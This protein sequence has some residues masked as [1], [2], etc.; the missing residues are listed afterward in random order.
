MAINTYYSIFENLNLDQYITDV[1]TINTTHI[2]V[3]AN[4]QRKNSKSVRTK[5]RIKKSAMLSV[6]KYAT[7]N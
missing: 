7:Q 4:R 6:N 5:Q 3:T 1:Q 2:W